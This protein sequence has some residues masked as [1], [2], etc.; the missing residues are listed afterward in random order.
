MSVYNCS[1]LAG[2]RCGKG[3]LGN[4]SN[5]DSSDTD[6]YTDIDDD[7]DDEPLQLCARAPSANL[8]RKARLSRVHHEEVELALGA[9][10]D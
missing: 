7:N 6:I 10:G 8:S 4:Q 5:I 1:T 2:D 9:R 3:G